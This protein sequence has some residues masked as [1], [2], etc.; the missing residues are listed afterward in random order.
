[1][2]Y[3]KHDAK[4]IFR[5]AFSGLPLKANFA[6]KKKKHW[7]RPEGKKM[8]LCGARASNRCLAY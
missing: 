1:M 4:K 3:G 8:Y 5:L 7:K 6:L 2:L